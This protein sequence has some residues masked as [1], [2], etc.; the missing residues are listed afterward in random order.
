MQRSALKQTEVKKEEK[1]ER[2]DPS[3]PE[4]DD[5]DSARDGPRNKMKRSLSD[6]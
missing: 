2:K 4:D 6:A 1:A 3:A 5:S